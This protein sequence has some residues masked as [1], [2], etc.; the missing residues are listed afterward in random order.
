MAE[1]RR[2]EEARR[3]LRE[4]FKWLNAKVKILLRLRS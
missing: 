4:R 2:H 1:R 3:K